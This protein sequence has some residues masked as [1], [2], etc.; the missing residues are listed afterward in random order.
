MHRK[1]ASGLVVAM[2]QVAQVVRTAEPCRAQGTVW[3][4]ASIF[5]VAVLIMVVLFAMADHPDFRV[6]IL[7]GGS[8]LHSSGSVHVAARR[9][10][11]EVP[12]IILEYSVKGRLGPGAGRRAGGRAGGAA[13]NLKRGEEVF[14]NRGINRR[15][16]VSGSCW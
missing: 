16:E 15:T 14:Q 2:Y 5:R 10:A 4:G 11:N 13:R 9:K 1:G 6:A 12:Y 8:I 7:C 3:T